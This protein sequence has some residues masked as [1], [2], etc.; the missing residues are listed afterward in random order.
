[1]LMLLLLLACGNPP[2]PVD[3]VLGDADL[4]CDCGIQPVD[5]L[6]CSELYC[7]EDGIILG[8][9]TCS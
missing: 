8:G 5:A 9:G 3:Q 4:P 7:T 2:C 6:T 1:M